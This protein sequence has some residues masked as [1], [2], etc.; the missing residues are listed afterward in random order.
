MSALEK[1]HTKAAAS[2]WDGYVRHMKM[3]EVIFIV[4]YIIFKNWD[5]KG[6]ESS[7]TLHGT[8]IRGY[9]EKEGSCW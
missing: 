2:I 5:F 4:S 6:R 7:I 9:M 3:V 1:K 8:T